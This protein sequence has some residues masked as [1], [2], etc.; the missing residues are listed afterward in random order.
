MADSS[1][2]DIVLSLSGSP[3][4]L[5][6]QLEINRSLTLR[7]GAS[8]GRRMLLAGAS[9]GRRVEL[10]R[11]G[12]GPALQ[13][14]GE[15][16]VQLQ[17]VGIRSVFSAGFGVV[18]VTDRVELFVSESELQGDANG[19]ICLNASAKVNIEGSPAAD[20]SF[21][22]G[23]TGHL[24]VDSRVIRFWGQEWLRWWRR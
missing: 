20:F 11:L 14:S 1:I 17:R 16:T 12:S 6:E 19:V 3:Y 24:F 23:W 10:N 5:D 15:G 8:Y 7:A 22:E 2:G 18:S 4:E 9:A 13:L 21:G